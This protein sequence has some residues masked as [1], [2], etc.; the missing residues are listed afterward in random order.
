MAVKQGE[1]VFVELKRTWVLEAR[2]E[3]GTQNECRVNFEDDYEGQPQSGRDQPPC[4]L[5]NEKER[6]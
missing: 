4:H 6:A 2:Q 5:P 1:G 3:P